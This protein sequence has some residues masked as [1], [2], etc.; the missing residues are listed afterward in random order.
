MDQKNGGNEAAV[1]V[2]GGNN[3]EFLLCAKVEYGMM[4]MG[5]TKQVFQD[6]HKLL[7]QP[8]TWIGDMAATMDVTLYLVG[9]INKKEAKESVSI[10]MGNKQVEKSVAIGDI[11]SMVCDNQGNQVMSALI[12]MLPWF[13]IAPSIFSVSPSVLR[14]DGS[15]E[16]MRMP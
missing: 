6:F 11:L 13:P 14:K 12:R 9:M 5:T 10:V 2:S 1:A 15:W 4:A 7:T 8:T 16:D 3:I